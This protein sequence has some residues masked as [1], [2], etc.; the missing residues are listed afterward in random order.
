MT[1][2]GAYLNE[3]RLV[4]TRTQAAA[5]CEISVSTFD[6]WVRKGIMPG[7]ITGTRRWSRAAI[8][9]SLMTE[10][11]ESPVEFGSSP[12]ETWKSTRAS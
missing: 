3:F 8:E 4:L 11:A 2:K 5:V 7:P 12:F 1:T 6:V 10:I 9:R